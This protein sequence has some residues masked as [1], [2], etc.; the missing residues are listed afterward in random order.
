MSKSVFGFLESVARAYASRYADLSRFCFV[1]PGKRSS[2]FFLRDLRSALPR[3]R[4][5]IAPETMTVSDFVVRI[6]GRDLAP[7]LDLLFILYRCYC[8]MNPAA[9]DGSPAVSFDSFRSWGETVLNDFD[10][11]DLYKVDPD[12]I[13]RN[14]K[15]FRDIATDFL[16]EE[17]RNV[18]EEYF[19]HNPSPDDVG[20]FW[21][22]FHPGPGGELTHVKRRFIQLWE[23]LA[24]LYHGL[25]N[26]LESMG[27][28]TV[29]GAY[30]LALSRLEEEG[31]D[32]LPW[33]KI[34]FV[35]F[36]ALS[37]VEHD[38]FS[39][40]RD[41]PSPDGEESLADFYWDATGPVLSSPGNSASRFVHANAR[42]FP[43]PE[44]SRDFL[45][46]SERDSM[47]ETLRV[48]AAPS[49]TIQAKLAG[50]IVGDMVA[51]LPQGALTDAKVAMVLPDESLLL[52]VLY[53]VPDDAGEIN[54][55]MGYPLRLTSAASFVSQL[56]RLQARKR[57]SHGEEGFYH[58]DL[59][60]FLA[61]PF[62]H[63]VAPQQ[64]L[65]LLR[66]QMAE[67]RLF[68][69]P[70]SLIDR[71][72]PSLSGVLTP[73]RRD[74]SPGEVIA[75]V[76]GALAMVE[77]ALD[78]ASG[79]IV[80]ASVDRA[81]ILEY[82][83]ALRQL[84]EVIS[85]YGIAMHFATVF[86]LVDR[87][88]S[89]RKVS[90]E[91][92]PLR[93]LQVMGLLETRA[94]D[95]EYLVIPSMNER[96]FPRKMRS[97]TFIPDSLRSGYGLPPSNY[98]ESLF[99]YYFFRLISRAREVWMLYDAS[100]GEGLR[101]GD[102]SRYILQLRHLYAPGQIETLKYA[103]PIASRS[104]GEVVVEKIPEVM[105]R[106][107][108]FMVPGSGKNFSASALRTYLS[109]PV[110]FFYESVMGIRPDSEA[111]V[112][113][114]AITL[115]N[116]FHRVMQL[117]YLPG[118]R[119]RIMHI[120]PRTVTREMIN[121]ILS[122]NA[123]IGRLVRHAVN[124]EV[125]RLSEEELDT[126]LKGSADLLA[127]SIMRQVADILR[128]DAE[129]AP[130]HLYG[131][132]VADTLPFRL[133]D[134]TEVNMTFSFDRLDRVRTEGGERIRVVDYK[135]GRSHLEADSLEEI[136]T[137]E[138][139]GTNVFQLLL[140]SRLVRSLFEKRGVDGDT[141]HVTA[142]IYSA[143]MIR[144]GKDARYPTFGGEAVDDYATVAEEFEHRLDSMLLEIMDPAKP[145]RAIPGDSRCRYC[146]L[147]RI[148]NA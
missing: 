37:V 43:S 4:V 10:E 148:C 42:D 134:G 143:S 128:H 85:R 74:C 29:G 53:S 84:S 138:T 18:M 68:V 61:H 45:L 141:A 36:N 44:W 114:D 82:R 119:E 56:R 65:A 8:R 133:S 3:G 98:Q 96:I 116:I 34:V 146:R 88:L 40:L 27:M 127:P 2:R 48:V 19:G 86:S 67:K 70:V 32:L 129:L 5:A 72:V 77:D 51:R 75:Y 110:R 39:L 144:T 17:Q 118:E 122:D 139:A 113:V 73:L 100:P 55:T 21:K 81:N 108:E 24:P 103:F 50:D 121:G 30:R 89:G 38:I 145:F 126:P 49:N 58:A 52:P 105:E 6:S 47:P 131:C 1:F 87:M 69:V 123:R 57:T 115:G 97:R 31:T 41:T 125:S 64:E 33:K 140:Y 95:F 124:R 79:E 99:S 76:D 28:A 71:T 66:R 120:P 54:L 35:G 9:S 83:T 20:R 111:E 102:V 137:G 7:R 117:V 62:V 130:F 106:I 112:G 90:F 16:T 135:T 80:K 94:L 63:L 93:G 136:F 109:C 25:D 104:A 12:E 22:N 14:I 101:T 91:G 59:R 13:F 26:E 92:E 147:S 11:V 60:T 46:A 23:S 78:G 142:E 107:R 15:D 132:E